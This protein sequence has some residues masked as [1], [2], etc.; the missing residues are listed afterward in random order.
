MTPFKIFYV[1]LRGWHTA[2]R[3]RIIFKHFSFCINSSTKPTS[4]KWKIISN[5]TP[6]TTIFTDPTSCGK[7]HFVLDLIEKEY[8]K[9]FDFIIINCPTLQWNNTYHSRA[10]MEN[11][12]KVWLIDPKHII[13]WILRCNRIVIKKVNGLYYWIKK[14][15]QLLIWSEAIFIIDDTITDK[16]LD[17]KRHSLFELTVIERH[18]DYYLWLLS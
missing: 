15:P 5:E 7:T 2:S 4:N 3:F 6:H 10:W 16:G 11:N 8:N 12:D 14:L 18:C 13:R 9:H 1:I 17:K